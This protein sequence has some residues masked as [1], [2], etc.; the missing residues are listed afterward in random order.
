MELPTTPELEIAQKQKQKVMRYAAILQIMCAGT[1]EDF[2]D[3]M[4]QEVLDEL[5]AQEKAGSV[6]AMQVRAWYS[7]LRTRKMQIVLLDSNF[8]NHTWVVLNET[9]EGSDTPQSS[10]LNVANDVLKVFVAAYPGAEIADRR[11]GFR[12]E[13]LPAEGYEKIGTLRRGGNSVV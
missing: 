11:T 1:S 9:P 7:G 8:K 10:A 13:H 12:P 3:N 4:W 6:L 2:S 5:A